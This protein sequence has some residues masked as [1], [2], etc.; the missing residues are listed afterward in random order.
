M[1]EDSALSRLLDG[2]EL[3]LNGEQ[4]YLLPP[5]LLSFD[6]L[7]VLRPLGFSLGTMK[8]NRFEPSH[9]LALWLGEKDA[10]R[11]CRMNPDSPSTGR[12]PERRG[13]QPF[14]SWQRRRACRAP[15][16]PIKGG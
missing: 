9:A 6:G 11:F 14:P 15:D 1:G 5:E 13:S 7:K 10:L 4:L 8:K 12:L 2:R 3:T 16:R